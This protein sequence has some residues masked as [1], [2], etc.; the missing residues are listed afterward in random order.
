MKSKSN[1]SPFKLNY[2][3]TCLIGF[4]FFGILLLWQVYDSWCPTILTE[5]FKEVFNTDSEKDVQYLVGIVMAFDNLAALIMLPIFGKLSDKTHTKIGKR[6]PFILVGTFVC[7]IAFPFIPVFFHFHNL[8]GTFVVMA[9]VVFFAMMYRNPAVALMPDMT[10]KPLRSKANGIINIMGYIGGAFATVLAIFFSFSKYLGTS[11]D[12]SI[13]WKNGTSN[14]WLIE[15]PFLVASVL[16]V[17]SALV[18]FFNVKENK[19]A[20]EIRGEMELGEK[21]AEVNDVKDDKPMTKANKIMLILIL[22]AEFLWFMSDNAVSTFIGNYT[23]FYLGCEHQSQ[24]INTIIGGVGSVLGFLIGGILAGKIGR[25]WTV[26]SGLS[27]AILG[28][29]IWV[30][31]STFI[32]INH[33]SGVYNSFPIYLYLVWFIKGFGMSLVHVNSFPMVVELCS[34]KKIGRFT[35]LYYASSMTAQTITPCLLGILLLP[36]FK[37]DFSFLPIY[38][39]ICLVFSIVVFAFVKNVKTNKSKIK[40]GLEALDVDE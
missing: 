22:V 26:F 10:P 25:K 16:M 6:M 5:L 3:R 18:L 1:S 15:G 4:A 32:P 30:M 37:F 21:L 34:S 39:I 8:I 9:I 33:V 19:I 40:T 29:F 31:C 11:E 17:I 24:M 12:T 23:I 7:A 38:S 36:Q 2:K 13:F 27:L 20:N 14:I 35:G 28:T